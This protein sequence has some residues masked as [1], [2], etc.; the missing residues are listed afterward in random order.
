[1]NILKT[2]NPCLFSWQVYTA[3]R[4]GAGVCIKAWR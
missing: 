3:D 4:E 2:P 1:M